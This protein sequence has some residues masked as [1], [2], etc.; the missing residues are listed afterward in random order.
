M[1]KR[2]IRFGDYDTAVH[3]WTLTGW[4]LGR[5]EQKTT[6]I[7]KP[8]GD[9]TWDLSTSLSDGIIKYKDRSLT[10][11]FECSEGTRMERETAIRHMVNTLDGMKLEIRLPDDPEHYVTGRIQVARE[12]NDMAH[13]AVTVT[14][15]CE[16]WKYAGAETVVVVTAGTEK[17]TLT[18]YNGGR[19]AA[20]PTLTVTGATVLL[21]YG[22][23][24]MAMG[25]G[26]YKWPNLLL[27]PGSHGVRY[28][29]NGT[30][31]FTYREAV[32]E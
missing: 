6:Y 30:I 25:P 1:K 15:T 24:S 17:Q 29:G 4:K 18:L 19:R 20:V 8:N 11:T 2:T 28:S 12:Y 16:P 23:A 7:D 31:A 26:T 10:A 32:L 14:A 9:G 22:N 5:A 21:E 27:T 3:G 13:A